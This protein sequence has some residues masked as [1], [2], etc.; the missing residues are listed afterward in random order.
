MLVSSPRS[1][2]KKDWFSGFCLVLQ[3]YLFLAFLGCAETAR[4]TTRN[5]SSENAESGR[6]IPHQSSKKES[7]AKKQPEDDVH[8]VSNAPKA[9]NKDKLDNSAKEEPTVVHEA[10]ALETQPAVPPKKL[11]KK[12]S[13]QARIGVESADEKELEKETLSSSPSQVLRE[14]VSEDSKVS[15]SNPPKQPLNGKKTI[16]ENAEHGS[17]SITKKDSVPFSESLSVEEALSTAE[18]ADQVHGNLPPEKA[19]QGKRPSKALDAVRKSDLQENTAVSPVS[20]VESFF[21]PQSDEEKRKVG[22]ESP[23]QDLSFRDSEDQT[24]SSAPEPSPVLETK[25]KRI[26]SNGSVTSGNLNSNTLELEFSSPHKNQSG[27]IKKNMHKSLGYSAK[28]DDLEAGLK[29]PRAKT[30]GWRTVADK[31][32]SSNQESV[33]RAL[34]ES[35]SKPAYRRLQE[36]IQTS[37]PNDFSSNKEDREYSKISIWAEGQPDRNRT[38]VDALRSQEKRFGKAL[39]WIRDK[40]RKQMDEPSNED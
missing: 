20:E 28:S 33:S 35:P 15:T 1:V 38:S 25:V 18:E 34:V 26:K 10:A 24:S 19:W 14:L 31:D 17:E 40:G 32:E 9:K 39:Q 12:D 4:Q 23:G 37:S 11:T 16:P 5:S 22:N 7:G 21:T 3:A 36:F 8:T 6:S 13:G 29:D 2:S 30:L 27:P